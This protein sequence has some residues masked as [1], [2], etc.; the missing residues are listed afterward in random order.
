MVCIAKLK[1]K[2]AL[3]SFP[4]QPWMEKTA[5]DCFVTM[6]CRIHRTGLNLCVF[7]KMVLFQIG[8]LISGGIW[9][10]YFCNVELGGKIWERGWQDPQTGLVDISLSRAMWKVMSFLVETIS[11]TYE[12]KD[13]TSNSSCKLW[14]FIE[15]VC[16]NINSRINYIIMV[17]EGQIGQQDVWIKFIEFLY[18]IKYSSTQMIKSTPLQRFPNLSKIFLHTLFISLY[19]GYTDWSLLAAMDLSDDKVSNLMYIMDRITT[20]LWLPWRCIPFK[21]VFVVR[22]VTNVASVWWSSLFSLIWKTVLWTEFGPS[23]GSL[24]SRVNQEPFFSVTCHF[25]LADHMIN[26]TYFRTT[27]V[28]GIRANWNSHCES[29]HGNEWKKGIQSR[30]L[31][32]SSGSGA[33]SSW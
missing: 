26:S 10:Q 29:R 11:I 16:K 13:W 18:Y 15:N 8:L 21:V 22:F 20:W 17:N 2:L 14:N 9:I 27:R 5:K 23:G 31:F 24:Y 6:L 25:V 33:G 28:A 1:I 4:N 30:C 12:R 19:G 3:I 7:R 32:G